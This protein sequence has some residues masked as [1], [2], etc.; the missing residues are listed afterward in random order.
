[1]KMKPERAMIPIPVN[2]VGMLKAVLKASAMELACT[3]LPT[4]PRAIMM[5]MEKK[6][7]SALLPKPS[8]M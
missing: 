4:K 3:M 2:Q 7:A 1:M 8:E 6:V 5:V